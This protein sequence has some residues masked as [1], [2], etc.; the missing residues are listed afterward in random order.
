MKYNASD[1]YS[2]RMET[3]PEGGFHFPSEGVCIGTLQSS[4][5]FPAL[6]DLFAQ[7]GVAFLYGSNQERTDVNNCLERIVWRLVSCL[8]DKQC[9]FIIFDGGNP[10]E[11]FNSLSLL[12]RSYF[13][14]SKRIFFDG[15]SVEFSAVLSDIYMGMPERMNKIRNSGRNNL[16]EFNENE[17]QETGIKYTFIVLSDFPHNVTAEQ[18]RLLSKIIKA[19]TQ[20]GVFVLCS[21]DM[22]TD[23]DDDIRVQRDLE[24]CLKEMLV[25]FPYNN[26][27]VFRNSQNDN[28]LNRY[29]LKLDSDP[30][31]TVESEEW[32]RTIIQRISTNQFVTTNFLNDIL[33][34]DVI[35]SKSSKN[36]LEIPVGKISSKQ[37]LNLTFCP[38]NDAMLAHCLI[39]GGTGSG[40]ST[41]LHDV[42]IN[43]A[44]MYSPEELQFILLDLKSVEFGL[45]AGLPHVRVLSTKSDREYGSNVL[46]FVT[47]EIERRKKLFGTVSSIEEFNDDVH[48]VPRLLVVIDEF[49]NL[50]INEGSLGDLHDSNISA[51]IHKNFSKILKEGRAFGIHLLLATQETNDINSISSYSQLIKL[52]IAL[53]MQTKGGFLDSLNTADPALLERGKGI[54]NDDFGKDGA[55]STF[56]FAF[57]G[58]DKKTHKQVIE[59]EIIEAVRK[60]SAEVYGTKSPC[61]KCF[62][63]GGG[64][65]MLEYNENVITNINEER[66]VV[67]VGSPVTVRREDIKFELLRKRGA[68]ILIAGSYSDYL[69]SLISVIH[70]QLIKQSNDSSRFYLITEQSDSEYARLCNNNRIS[71]VHDNDK[72][73]EIIQSIN[74]ILL[75]CQ[76]DEVHSHHRIV[77]TMV[78]LR[79]FDIAKDGD[80]RKRLEN[81]IVNGPQYGIHVILHTE[82]LSDFDKQFQKDYM[83]FGDDAAIS[84]E[85]LIRE[86]SIKIELQGT[87]GYNIYARQDKMASPNE[88]FLANIQTKESGE[89]TKF[90]IYQQ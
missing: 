72:L 52:R 35:W 28:L 34:P 68:N 48:H 73:K 51:S 53:K 90:S 4:S 57:Y 69:Q 58:N 47:Q 45:Y 82:R 87:D 55:N 88:E 67:Y 49:Q 77:L 83:A 89:I 27:Y 62:Y 15:S 50:F 19:G 16:L 8:S 18:K 64:E 63:R 40:K 70:D 13:K 36:G 14:T 12:H 7:K 81:I 76:S 33:T 21:W 17:N 24:N 32:S 22:N 86:F 71:I 74:D 44:W 41:L 6:I 80:L 5:I 79:N 1:N 61:E 59:S 39:G 10:G 85:E 38:P 3:I 20:C 26:R 2:I 9:E 65:S 23:M 66:C 43:A 30:V 54:Y 29:I 11:H 78:G 37:L 42:I 84:P 75:G 25:L 56:N 46:M 31:S 60:K